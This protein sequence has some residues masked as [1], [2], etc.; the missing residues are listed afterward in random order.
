MGVMEPVVFVVRQKLGAGAVWHY[1]H[2]CFVF[3]WRCVVKV[4][5]FGKRCGCLAELFVLNNRPEVKV[6]LNEGSQPEQIMK[7]LFKI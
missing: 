4:F 7:V 6:Y 2:W 5:G 3:F 1:C